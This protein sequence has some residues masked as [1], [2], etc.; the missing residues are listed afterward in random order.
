VSVDDDPIQQLA[1]ASEQ[2][3]LLIARVADEQWS[4]PTP[5]A[6]WNVRDLVEHIC[7]SAA[8]FVEILRP[9]E[10]PD[11]VVSA[12]GY[13]ANA[14]ELVAALREPGVLEKSYVVPVGTVPGAVVV[15]LRLTETLVHGWDLAQA[16]GQETRFD[17]RVAEQ[18]LAFTESALSIVPTDRKPFASPQPVANSA[19]ALDRLAALL[20][21]SVSA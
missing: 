13:R 19:T 1:V 9:G 15:H 20:G 17:D 11:S 16:T 2:L 6:D 10:L 3:A 12:D 14:R 21:R 18:E 7:E 5:C 4:S 8:R